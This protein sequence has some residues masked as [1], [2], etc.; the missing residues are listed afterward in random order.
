VDFSDATVT[1]TKSKG[2]S[3]SLILLYI[4]NLFPFRSWSACFYL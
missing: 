2:N 3:H 4:V 1:N